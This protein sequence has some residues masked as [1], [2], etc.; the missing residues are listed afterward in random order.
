MHTSLKLNECQVWLQLLDQPLPTEALLAEIQDVD[1]GA[2]LMFLGKARRR[3]AERITTT[4]YYQAYES[5][6]L[7]QLQSLATTATAQWPLRQLRIIHRLGEVPIGQTSIAIAAASP[8]RPAVMEAIPWLMD[9]I[10]ESVPIWK[11]ETFADGTEQWI[12]P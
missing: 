10:K 12:H 3:T 5:M 2:H 9:Q 4:L 8:H 11:R 1:C 7:S 6:A